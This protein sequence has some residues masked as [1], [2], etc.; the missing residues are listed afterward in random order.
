MNLGQRQP[1]CR[2]PIGIMQKRDLSVMPM[3][4][5][6]IQPCR[7]LEPTG[8]QGQINFLPAVMASERA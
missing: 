2:L 7:E 3:D 6:K 4:R 1:V 5:A 8:G